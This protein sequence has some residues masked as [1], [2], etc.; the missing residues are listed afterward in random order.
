M[1]RCALLCCRVR[2]F[3]LYCTVVLYCS[4]VYILSYS[5]TMCFAGLCY[6]MYVSLVGVYTLILCIVY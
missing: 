1:Q 6:A 3:L 5:I 4:I 2:S